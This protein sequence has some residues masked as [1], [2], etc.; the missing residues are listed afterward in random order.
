[1]K[2]PSWRRCCASQLNR[3]RE[4][5]H[6]RP[7]CWRRP[8]LPPSRQRL[9]SQLQGICWRATPVP[10]GTAGAGSGAA[11]RPR[12]DMR[13]EL[14]RLAAHVEDAR[15]MLA[16]GQGVGRKLDFL[17]PGIQPR[18]QYA[19]LQILRHRPDAASGWR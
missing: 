11:G 1:M 17:S 3:D 7:G 14:D 15:A 5:D 6:G 16:D 8:S 2:A 12:R 9:E 4:T 19:L 18:G 10:R 13:E